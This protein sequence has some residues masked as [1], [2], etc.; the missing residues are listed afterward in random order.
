MTVVDGIKSPTIDSG[1]LI[2]QDEE[3]N[4]AENLRYRKLLSQRQLGAV[5]ADVL[6]LQNGT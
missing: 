4:T 2:C 1:F 3:L 6:L 5:V